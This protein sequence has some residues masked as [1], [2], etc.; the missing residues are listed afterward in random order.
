ML[1]NQALYR[2]CSVFLSH[3]CYERNTYFVLQPFSYIFRKPERYKGTKYR[4]LIYNLWKHLW[5]KACLLPNTV[6]N[7]II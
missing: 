2:L 4:S 3:H 7:E 5:L 6:Y 1:R